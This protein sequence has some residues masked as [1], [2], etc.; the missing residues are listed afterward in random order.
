MKTKIFLVL[1][2]IAFFA[3]GFIWAYSLEWEAER[4]IHSRFVQVSKPWDSQK[5]R[6]IASWWMLNKTNRTPE[7][8]AYLADSE[9]GSFVAY[10]HKPDC[11][12]EEGYDSYSNERHMFAVCK[13]DAIFQKKTAILNIRMVLEKDNWKFN[14]FM[15][16]ELT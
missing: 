14:D 6:K 1:L 4:E 9:L 16:I 11:H 3:H 5:L 10:R 2:L 7:R 12:L 8:M 13:I 15:S